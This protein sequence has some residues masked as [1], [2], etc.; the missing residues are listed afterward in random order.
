VFGWT[1]DQRCSFDLLDAFT[2]AGFD[3]ID[4]ADAYSAW[5]PGHAGGESETVIGNWLAVRGRNVGS[6]RDKIVIATKVAKWAKHPGL[7]TGQYHRRLRRIAEA[8]QDRLYRSLP[9]A[10]EDDSTPQDATLE[11][12]GRLMVA[13]KVRAVGASNFWRHQTGSVAQDFRGRRL[14]R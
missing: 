9:V 10:E 6:R 8:A 5:V 12:Y 14:P 11:A 4:T 13:G 2:A 7:K 3:F 1:A